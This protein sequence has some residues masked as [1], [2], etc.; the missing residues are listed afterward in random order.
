MHKLPTWL[1]ILDRCPTRDIMRSWGIGVDPACLLCN[2][3]S[4][5]RNHLFFDC[6]YT[7]SIW[8]RLC[9]KLRLPWTS[10]S[11]D[12]ILQIL[13][14]FNGHRNHRFLILLAWQT[15]IYE[16]W[17]ERNNRLHRQINRSTDAIYNQ[18]DTT[19]R[20]R[21]SSF[22]QQNPELGS[23]CMQLWFALNW[24]FKWFYTSGWLSI[25][26]YQKQQIEHIQWANPTPYSTKGP[27]PWTFLY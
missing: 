15:L 13:I 2:E 22:C 10:G 25:F 6:D 24:P 4:E 14:S 9:H 23:A 12:T 16:T 1:F 11:L 18:I 21:I 19:I 27:R 26:L 20:N 3:E 5:S 7:R 17:K 8:W